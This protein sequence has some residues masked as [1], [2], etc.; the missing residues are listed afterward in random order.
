MWSV[1]LIAGLML[2]SIVGMVCSILGA[3]SR[4]DHGRKSEEV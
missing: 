3:T 4:S 2:L 1:I